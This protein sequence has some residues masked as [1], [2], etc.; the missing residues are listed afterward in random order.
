[1]GAMTKRENG[2][3]VGVG[4]ALKLVQITRDPVSHNVLDRIVRV[5][6]M[7][8]GSSA[9]RNKH[10]FIFPLLPFPFNMQGTSQMVISL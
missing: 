5:Q 6:A 2:L 10:Q 4:L 7:P 3:L 1:M 9:S 8:R